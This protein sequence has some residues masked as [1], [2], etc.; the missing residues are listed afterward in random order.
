MRVVDGGGEPHRNLW[1]IGFPVEGPHFYT[2]A[3][4]RPLMNSRF[5]QD[6]RRCVAQFLEALRERERPACAAGAARTEGATRT[7]GVEGPP[8]GAFRG[9][10]RAGGARAPAGIEPSVARPRP[11]GAARDLSV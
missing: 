8:A 9:E 1:A 4:P 11:A 3:L 10:G 5:T 7:E 2:H 6:A